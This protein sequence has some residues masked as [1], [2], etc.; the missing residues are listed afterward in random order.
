MPTRTVGA[1]PSLVC[2]SSLRPTVAQSM[3]W[4]A[5][6]SS[7]ESRVKLARA[8]AAPRRRG[9]LSRSCDLARSWAHLR[10]LGDV[11]RVGRLDQLLDRLGQV[12]L[13]QPRGR[14]VLALGDDAIVEFEAAGAALLLS[15][16]EPR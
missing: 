7:Q 10:P 2:P 6:V 16:L 9:R 1:L 12:H 8:A 13:L 14:D 4:P 3:T 5:P 15:N 11:R